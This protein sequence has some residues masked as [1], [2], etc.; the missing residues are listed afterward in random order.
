MALG[1]YGTRQ[2]LLIRMRATRL[3]QDLPKNTPSRS[4][5]LEVS[6]IQTLELTIM[7]WLFNHCAT[8]TGQDNPAFYILCLLVPAAGFKPLILCF[9]VEC[10][11]TVPRILAKIILPF[12]HSI[13]HG[14][15]SMFQ[16]LA[17]RIM[18]WVFNHC[19]TM[20]GKI[21][22]DF[23]TFYLSWSWYLDLRILILGSWS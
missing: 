1:H 17:L 22:Y 16:T 5:K 10:S 11:T 20:S 7:S 14:T 4:K 13:F 8:D 15:K 21:A 23:F 12:L 6:I 2:R 9:W 19:T 18:S 3:F